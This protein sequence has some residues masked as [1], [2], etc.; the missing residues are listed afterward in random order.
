M[1]GSADVEVN[2]E[3]EKEKVIAKRSADGLDS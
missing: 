2:E 3:D 1:F